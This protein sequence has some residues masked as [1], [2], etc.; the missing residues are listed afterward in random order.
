V[1]GVSLFRSSGPSCELTFIS[2]RVLSFIQAVIQAWGQGRIYH[3]FTCWST[4]PFAACYLYGACPLLMRVGGDFSCWLCPLPLAFDIL[5]QLAILI[6][7]LGR[8]GKQE[9]L[10]AAC[11][12]IGRASFISWACLYGCM[13]GL[14]CI[15]SMCGCSIK[16]HTLSFNQTFS[17]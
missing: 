6:S 5:H 12:K 15:K 16:R 8:R 4:S 1:L 3:H 13:C 17:S 11:S 10:V 2:R 9:N 7:P 14:I